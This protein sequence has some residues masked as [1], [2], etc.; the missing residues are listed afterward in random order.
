MTDTPKKYYLFGVSSGSPITYQFLNVEGA[1]RLFEGTSVY[2]YR[3]YDQ[4]L[5][6]SD[7]LL[8]S[9]NVIPEQVDF[10]TTM[11][12]VQS[13]SDISK[14]NTVV[15][16]SGVG[17]YQTVPESGEWASTGSLPSG[18][19]SVDAVVSLSG[20]ISLLVGNQHFGTEPRVVAAPRVVPYTF[21]D[22]DTGLPI[23]DPALIV[24]LDI[25]E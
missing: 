21:S 20:N 25:V 19:Y 8:S 15:F 23:S 5:R 3:L 2:V 1:P 11:A 6:V 18:F 7:D 4:L 14:T 13:D 10:V 16:S 9:T 12:Q 22:S 17:V 24:D